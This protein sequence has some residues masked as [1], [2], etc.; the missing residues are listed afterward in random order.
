MIIEEKLDSP[1][2]LPEG[3]TEIEQREYGKTRFTFARWGADAA[4]ERDGG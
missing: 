1:V 3:F 4:P 2:T